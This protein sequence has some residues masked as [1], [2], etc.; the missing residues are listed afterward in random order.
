MGLV[1]TLHSPR[2]DGCENGSTGAALDRIFHSF[3]VTRMKHRLPRQ[4]QQWVYYRNSSSS[5]VESRGPPQGQCPSRSA[6][7]CVQMS[8]Y[9]GPRYHAV[10]PKYVSTVVRLYI[11]MHVCS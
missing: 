8:V 6:Y 2:P 3:G 4:V 1:E 10:A 7:A 5:T 9:P 11:E